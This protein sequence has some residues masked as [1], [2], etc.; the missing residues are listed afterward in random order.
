M[1][2]IRGKRE[3]IFVELAACAPFCCLANASRFVSWGVFLCGAPSM[4]T[5]LAPC[6]VNFRV[7]FVNFGINFVNCVNFG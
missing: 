4:A 6:F 5:S 7:N 3:Q 2:G 1:K